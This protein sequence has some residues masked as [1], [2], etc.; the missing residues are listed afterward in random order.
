M[1]Q[2]ADVDEL[3][4]V[5]FCIG[6]HLAFRAAFDPRIAATVCFYPTGLHNGALGADADAGSLARAGGIRGR[7][8][9]V[10]GSRDQHVPADA[11]VQIVSALYA[12]GL[13]D[14]HVHLGARVFRVRQIHA[15]ASV[16]DTDCA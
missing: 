10:F 6:G 8:M 14:V 13:D 16:D 3:F 4:A 9:I 2:R 15:D 1:V 7:L 11:R 12:A 5:G